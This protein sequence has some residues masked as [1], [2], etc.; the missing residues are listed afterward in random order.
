MKLQAGQRIEVFRIQDTYCPEQMPIGAFMAEATNSRF[1]GNEY[2]RDL[3]PL[4]PMWENSER[5]YPH[6]NIINKYVNKG[7]VKVGA[8]IIKEVMNGK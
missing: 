8:M 1:Y 3:I 2:G 4:A 6:Q 5:P 7:M